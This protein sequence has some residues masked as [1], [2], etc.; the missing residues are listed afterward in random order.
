MKLLLDTHTFLWA[1]SFP[2]LLSPS[3]RKRIQA[4]ETEQ[5]LVSAIS[6]WEICKLAQKGKIELS[7][8]LPQ[9]IKKVTNHPKVSMIDIS[10]EI[11]LESC[12]LPGT[13]HLDPADQM[14]VATARIHQ[15]LLLTKDQKIL[16][17]PHVKAE[18]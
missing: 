7:E 4:K 11:A 18:W 12:S 15:A 16:S 13:F 17:Y 6:I 9:W 1:S 8:P 2:E 14:I 3:V 10:G 5:I